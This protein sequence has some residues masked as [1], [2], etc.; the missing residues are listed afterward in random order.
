MDGMTI[1]HIVSIDHGSNGDFQKWGYPKSWMIWGSLILGNLQMAL[2]NFDW[3]DIK[4]CQ[5][6]G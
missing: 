5:D 4:I 3:L 6:D 2:G 1:N